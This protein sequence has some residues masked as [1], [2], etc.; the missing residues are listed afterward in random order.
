MA[1]GDVDG[2]ATREQDNNNAIDLV[3]QSS[4]DLGR[5]KI[6]FTLFDIRRPQS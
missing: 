4:L 1:G 2:A 6:E 5:G 3:Y